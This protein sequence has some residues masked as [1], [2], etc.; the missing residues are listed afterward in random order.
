MKRIKNKEI[1]VSQL[2]KE[3]SWSHLR[4]CNRGTLMS[5]QLPLHDCE[6][7]LVCQE[8]IRIIP[9]K[10]LVAA[11]K[12]RD[13]E[14]VAKLFYGRH[15]ARHAQREKA[16]INALLMGGVLPPPLHF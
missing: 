2:I 14:V 8:V 12:W 3:I 10:R 13:K 9:N 4:Q 11:R 7:M 6:G 1:N 16:G 15:A 5:F